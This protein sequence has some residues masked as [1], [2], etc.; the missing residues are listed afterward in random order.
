M[1]Q[2]LGS[3][4]FGDEKP[5]VG[6]PRQDPPFLENGE[7]ISYRCAGDAIAICHLLR[8]NMLTTTEATGGDVLHDAKRQ[9]LG[10]VARSHDLVSGC[11]LLI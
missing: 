7:S 9:F 11:I 3:G 10:Q 2:A 8:A 1:G 5:P 4:V 6:H